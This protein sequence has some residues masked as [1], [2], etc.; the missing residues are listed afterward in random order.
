[1]LSF[2]LLN[3]QYRGDFIFRLMIHACSYHQ[4]TFYAPVTQGVP[5]EPELGPL[6]F[7]P[8]ASPWPWTNF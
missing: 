3:F 5:Q 2:S 7:S 6:L 4:Q 1:M 8:H